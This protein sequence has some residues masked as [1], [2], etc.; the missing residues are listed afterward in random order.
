MTIKA[1]AAGLLFPDGRKD[2]IRAAVGAVFGIFLTGYLCRTWLHG[3][4][5]LPFLIAPMGAS[6]VLLFA[7]PAS[8]L[9][10]PW[11]IFGGNVV[12]A[13]AGVACAQ[14]VHDPLFAAP[15]AVAAAIAGMSVARCVHPPGG[16]VALSAV[17]GGP[18]ILAAGYSFALVPVATNTALLLVLGSIFNNASGHPYPHRPPQLPHDAPVTNDPVA[19]D[20]VSFTIADVDEVLAALEDKPDVDRDEL[21]T[22]F[23]QVE[24]RAFVRQSDHI[25]CADIMSRDVVWAAASETCVDALVTLRTRNVAV[26]PVVDAEMRV[27]GQVGIAALVGAGDRLVSDVMDG[28]PCLAAPDQVASELVPLLSDGIHHHAIITAADFTL[29]G[30]VSQTDLLAALWRI[31][32]P[33]L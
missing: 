21:Y 2:W 25:R 14:L 28:S 9:A 19:Q 33:Q 22:L 8:P 27:V 32:E 16:A 30:L 15:I 31:P 4:G 12:S 13:L 26:M 6:S 29:V 11:S 24:A 1:R 23:C 5:G 3:A 20:R 10:R 17:L 7:V 18:A